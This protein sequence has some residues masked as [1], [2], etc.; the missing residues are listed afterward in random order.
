MRTYRER[1]R[2]AWCG[3]RGHHGSTLDLGGDEIAVKCGEVR[4][5]R[6]ALA[7]R[8]ALA[9]YTALDRERAAGAPSRASNL[10]RD[11]LSAISAN[12]RS[13]RDESGVLVPG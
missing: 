13:V 6:L 3:L 8:Q 7:R 11:D 5:L 10:N 9:R 2:Q 4:C 12:R 1:I